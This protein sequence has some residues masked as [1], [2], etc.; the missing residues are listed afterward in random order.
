MNQN[1]VS[2]LIPNYNGEP[3]IAETLE[4]VLTAAQAYPGVCEVLVVDDA[5]TDRSTEIIET[6]FPQVR[7]I[8]HA[9]N[10]GFAGAVHT[11]VNAA[12][13]ERLILLN[14]DV[15]PDPLFIAPLI[16]AIEAPTVFAASPMVTDRQG[17]PMFLS[18]SRYRIRHGKLKSIPWDMQEVERRRAD[19]LPLK[20]LY[21]SGGST[22]VRRSRFLELG[23]FLDIY[24]PFY[25]EDVDLGMRAW[26]HGWETRFVP[27]SRVV[28]DGVGTIKRLFKRNRVRIIQLRNRLCFFYLYS[29]PG[30][31]ARAYLPWILLRSITSLLRLDPNYMTALLHFAARRSKLREM[32]REIVGESPSVTL[33]SVLDEICH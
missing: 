8:R 20:A 4:T 13:H 29:A 32:R 33:E 27:E 14:S 23:G 12:S 7:L 24:E 3:I 6:A 25:W 26:L 17:D 22:A 30:Q 11:G 19:G 15:H 9:H 1:S 28:H 16:D 5:S 21:A 2:I 18:W 10:Q 31:F